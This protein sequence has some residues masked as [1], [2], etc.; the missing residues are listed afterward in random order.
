MRVYIG[1]RILINGNKKV[2]EDSYSVLNLNYYSIAL[3]FSVSGASLRSEKWQGFRHEAWNPEVD[4]IY[5]VSG[6]H[7][8]S[9]RN[10]AMHSGIFQNLMFGFGEEV[11]LCAGLVG[12]WK[13]E[14]D[15][16][17]IKLCILIWCL[18]YVYSM[19]TVC[20]ISHGLVG[21]SFGWGCKLIELFV[22]YSSLVRFVKI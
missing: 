6:G 4:Q 5:C 14:D 21:I 16:I 22:R 18:L 9:K 8:R 15:V 1:M 13:Y 19:G 17:R 12:D 3:T 11:I 10:E 7:R 2:T 20:G